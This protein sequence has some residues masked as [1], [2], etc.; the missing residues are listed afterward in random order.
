MIQ[1][2]PSPAGFIQFC[3]ALYERPG[4][5]KTCLALQ[6]SRGWNVNCLL[7]CAWAARLGYSLTPDFWPHARRAIS[8]L[9]SDAVTPIRQLRRSISKHRKLDEDLK[10]GI[11]R[12]LWYAELRAEQAVESALHR[13]MTSYAPAAGSDP[14]SNLIACTGEDSPDVRRLADLFGESIEN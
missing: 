1:Y 7:L 13:S 12:L 5:A 3:A 4:V 10:A 11:K 14:L 2:E 9:D 8:I 6:D